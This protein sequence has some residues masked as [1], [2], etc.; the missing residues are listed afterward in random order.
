MDQGK[1]ENIL[2]H[3][4][5]YPLKGESIPSISGIE[6]LDFSTA[7]PK[8]TAH[9]SFDSS[10]NARFEPSRTT[11][12][13]GS[14]RISNPGGQIRFKLNLPYKHGV[15]LIFELRRSKAENQSPCPVTIKIN[16]E[17]WEKIVLDK[18]NFHKLSWYVT[19]DRLVAG[20]N[21][22]TLKLSKKAGVSLLLKS[23]SVMR[24]NLQH[25]NQDKWCWAAVTTSIVHFFDPDTSLTQCKVVELCKGRATDPKLAV[26]ECCPKTKARNEKCGEV[27]KSVSNQTHKLSE[28][29]KKL[30]L[31]DSFKE[32]EEE[33][34]LSLDVIRKE[35]N[36]GLPIAVR[37]GWLDKNGN[38]S[39]KGH[40]VV[41]TGVG[42]DDPRGDD[43][44]WVR[45]ANPLDQAAS[46]LPFATLKNNY[47]GHG[48]LTHMYFIKKY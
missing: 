45:V 20:D 13:R 7:N 48:K 33:R 47:Q 37:I 42:P 1:T 6:R 12:P 21:L 35:I 25:Q 23:V 43:Y 19:F 34:P 32:F 28:A 41:I 16:D 26:T 15:I 11:P 8:S 44:T 10:E 31:L 24:F 17:K 3:L 38:L 9:F 4:A 40:F 18:S 27:Y 22:I 5:T 39:D 29:L 2:Q 30:G 46:Y 14:W 36:A